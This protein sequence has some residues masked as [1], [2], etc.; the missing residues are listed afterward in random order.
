MRFAAA[1]TAIRMAASRHPVAM[2]N[3]ASQPAL[4]VVIDDL[5]QAAE[6]LLDGLSLSDEHLEHPVLDPLRHDEVMAADF[7][8][9]LEFPIDTAV[10]LLDASGIP[11]QDEM[12]QVRAV[13]LKV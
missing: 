4:D 1:R 11:G 9:R 13:C 5:R 7:I 12:K 3:A 6:F 10:A 2:A 8:G